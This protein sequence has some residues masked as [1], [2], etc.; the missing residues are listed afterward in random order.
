MTCP[1]ITVVSLPENWRLTTSSMASKKSTTG[2]TNRRMNVD[3]DNPNL[4]TSLECSS[5]PS[6]GWKSDRAVWSCSRG[7]LLVETAMKV[8]YHPRTDTLSLVLKDHAT[9]VESDED[10]PGVILDYDE[11][12]DLASLEILDASR[13]VTE[14]K[15]LEF[16]LADSAGIRKV[17]VP[18]PSGA[19]SRG[20]LGRTVDNPPRCSVSTQIFHYQITRTPQSIAQGGVSERHLRSK[21]SE[22]FPGQG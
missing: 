1:Q 11:A 14:T 3:I 4:V 16:Q 15:R 6:S 19:R 7:W 2:T 5:R 18:P 13:R 12:G 21:C 22:A 20:R 9:V 10:K 17:V 8:T